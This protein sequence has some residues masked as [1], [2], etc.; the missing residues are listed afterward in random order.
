MELNFIFN[1]L[2]N[3]NQ[4]VYCRFFS[5]ILPAAEIEYELGVLK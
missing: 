5:W 4:K 3:L 1:P 2:I